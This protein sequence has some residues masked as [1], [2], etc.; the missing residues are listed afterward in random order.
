MIE[1]PKKE[2]QKQIVELLLSVD[3]IISAA[4]AGE[5]VHPDNWISAREGLEALGLPSVNTMYEYIDDIIG[6]DN[7]VVPELQKYFVRFY[8]AQ[9]SA[10]ARLMTCSDTYLDGKYGSDREFMQYVHFINQNSHTALYDFVYG[11]LVKLNE[12]NP[13]YHK[14]LTD[15]S[16]GW[17]F[18]NNWLDGVGGA[19]NSLIANRISTLKDNLPRIEQLYN[20]LADSISRRSLNALIKFWL[21]WDNTDWRAISI[22]YCDVVDTSVYM[23]YDDEV[24]VDCGS[25]IGDTVV[26]YINAVNQQ[27]KRVY[28]YDISGKSIDIIKQNLGQI[29]NIDIRHKGTGEF[30]TE[31]SVVGVDQ[32][33]HGNK[34]SDSNQGNVVEK[35]QVVRLDDD[36]K[37]PISFLK[38]DVEGVDKETLRGAKNHIRHTHPKIHV[39]SYHR[40]ADIVD[41][42]E[43]IWEIDPTYSI[44]FRLINT[45]DNPPRFPTPA[46]LAV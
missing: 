13:N 43:L 23:F 2:I 20:N 35:V 32:A 5:S 37:E 22:C 14:L 33:F 28:T 38:V 36:I 4:L 12:K 24:F 7:S 29:E 31:M 39:D 21:T 45:V 16:K 9:V 17:Y 41:V 30:N 1:Q 18:E 8:E 27:F 19:N 25:Y 42:P 6:G 44:Y 15:D 34:L 46:F 26:Q 11:N 10:Y 40:L 3:E